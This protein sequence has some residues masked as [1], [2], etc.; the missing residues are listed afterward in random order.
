MRRG[1]QKEL[2]GTRSMP[3]C[4]ARFC[5]LFLFY[6]A[7]NRASEPEQFQIWVGGVGAAFLTAVTGVVLFLALRE[8]FGDWTSFA[9]VAAFLFATPVWSVSANALWTHNLTLLGIAIAM[10]FAAR[11]LV[12]C[13]LRVC[14]RGCFQASCGCHSCCLGLYVAWKR[15]DASIVPAVGLTSVTGLAAL[16]LGIKPSS[17][18]GALSEATRRAWQRNSVRHLVLGPYHYFANTLGFLV[19]PDRGLFT[20]TPAIL[21]L[22]ASMLAHWRNLPG[23][24]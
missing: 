10:Y 12:A 4:L 15:R 14:T 11:P 21:L 20:W 7:L 8:R 1:S 17:T 9:A 2:T 19:G 13:W 23:L 3:A 16:S 5:L 24:G 6:A 18:R 22:L